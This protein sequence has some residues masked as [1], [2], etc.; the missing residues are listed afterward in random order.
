MNSN[1]SVYRRKDGYWIAKYKDIEGKWKYIYR[2]TKAEA[3][4][5]LREALNDI[6]EGITTNT[7]LTVNDV[8]DSWLEGLKDTVGE[9]TWVNR[10]TIVRVHIRPHSIGSRKLSKLT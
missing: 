10:E 5:A 6:D 3:K 1:G 2:K 7:K 4:A 9:R 8:V